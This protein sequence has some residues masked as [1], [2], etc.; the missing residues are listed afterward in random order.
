MSIGAAPAAAEAPMSAGE[1]T[2]VAEAIKL[3]G[4]DMPGY[5]EAFYNNSRRHSALGYLSPARRGRGR[6]PSP[7]WGGAACFALS[8]RSATSAVDRRE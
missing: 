3:T 4:E 5:I 7:R 1:A 6:S 2:S 8:R